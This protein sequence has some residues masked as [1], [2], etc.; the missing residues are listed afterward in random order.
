MYFFQTIWSPSFQVKKSIHKWKTFKPAANLCAMFREIAEN[1]R[2]ISLTLKASF[3][4]L[5]EEA[6]CTKKRKK[7]STSLNKYCLFRKVTRRKPLFLKKERD[8]GLQ[9]FIWTNL[10]TKHSI[11]TQTVH[12]NWHPRWR[13]GDDLGLFCSHRNQALE[14][15]ESATDSCVPKVFY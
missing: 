15:I 7:D 14:I 13:G 3:N 9:S 12:T 2:A 6:H 5:N 1:P 11:S 8:L 4:M 10:K